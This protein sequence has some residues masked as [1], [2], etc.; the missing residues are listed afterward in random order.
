MK[1]SGSTYWVVIVSLFFAYLLAIVPLPDWALNWRPQWVLLFVFYWTMALPYRVGLGLS[2]TAGLLLDVL[3][4][5]IN[6]PIDLL[7]H[8]HVIILLML[9]QLQE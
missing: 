9:P 2:W 5:P 4:D 1:P 6:G 3:E 7:Q 8:H